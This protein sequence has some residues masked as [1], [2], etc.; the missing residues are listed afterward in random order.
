MRVAATIR[1]WSRAAWLQAA[2][3]ACSAGCTCA[4]QAGGSPESTGQSYPGCRRCPGPQSPAGG[5]LQGADGRVGVLK[6]AGHACS[7]RELGAGCTVTPQCSPLPRRCCTLQD[8][9]HACRCQPATTAVGTYRSWQQRDPPWRGR[10]MP[11]QRGRAGRHLQTVKDRSGAQ[12]HGGAV[13]N[14]P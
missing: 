2:H 1:Q 4:C 11:R 10:G 9:R 13:G 8:G 5:G 12:K 7:A 3:G 6:R 14:A